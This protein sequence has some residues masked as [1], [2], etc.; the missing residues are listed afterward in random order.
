MAP[1]FCRNQISRDALA[2]G[3][4]ENSR[5]PRASARRLIGQLRGRWPGALRLIRISMNRNLTAAFAVAVLFVASHLQAQLPGTRLDSVFP[6]GAQAGQTVGVTISGI[7]L[8]DVDRL[9]FSHAGITAVRK[10]AEPGPFDNGPQPVENQFVVTVRGDVPP[11]QHEV[12]CQGKYGLSNP[13]TFVVDTLTQVVETEPNQDA[14]K[15]GEIT[16]PGVVTGQLNGGADVDLFRF[17]ANGGQ[18]LLIDGQ[19]RRIDSRSDVVLTVTAA[20]GRILAENRQGFAGDP[21]I[22]LTIPA[23]GEYYLQVRDSLYQGGADFV[24]RIVLSSRPHLDFVFPPAGAAGSNDEYTIYGRNLPGGQNSPLQIDGQTLQQLNVRI[25]IPGDIADKLTF[26]S[27]LDPHQAGLDGIEYRVNSPAGP[28][29]PILI[30]A[31]TAGAVREQPENNSPATAQKLTLPCEV[32]GQF[33]PQRDMDWYTFDAKANEVFFIEVYSH[34]LGLPTDPGLLVQRITKTDAGEEQV[35]QVVW[36]DDVTSN[37]R[38]KEFDHRTNDPWY[39]FTAPADGTYRVMVRDSYSAVKSDPRLVY[40]LAI[41]TEQPDFRLAAAPVDLQGSILL[42]KGAREAIRVTA[43]RR[44]GYEGEIRL[45]AEGLPNGVTSEEVVIGP[46]SDYSTLVLTAAENAPGGNGSV[47]IVGKGKVGNAEVTRVARVGRP[48]EPIQF[49]QPNS[50]VASISARL[51]DGIQLTVSDAEPALVSLTA[52][53]GKVIE[54]ARGGVLKIPYQVKRAE[55]AGGNITGFPIGLPPNVGV[56]QVGIGGNEKGD[57]ELRLQA[58]TPP[59]KYTFYLASMAQGV[60]YSRNPEAAE[61]AKKRQEEMAK[62]LMDAQQKFQ[63]SQQA[64]QQATNNLNQANNELNAANSAKTQADQAA[65]QAAAALKTATDQLNAAKQQL[66]TKPDDDGLKQA[67]ATAEANEK[68]AAEKSKAATEAATATAK[69]QEEAVAKQKAAQEAKTKADQEQQEA[70]QFQT[71]AQQEK[72]RADQK[73]QQT[74]QQANKRAFNFNTAS[75]PVTIQIAE[76][77]IT[78]TGPDAAT[79]K[80]GEAVD[81]PFKVTRLYEFNANVSVQPQL[82]GGVGGLSIP[83]INIDQNNTEGTVKITAA[84]NATPGEHAMTFR[85][86]M[87]FNGQNL[88]LDHPLKLTVVAVE[89]K[90]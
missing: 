84:A 44:D 18:R 57:F 47:R 5:E 87:N 49:Q 37:D 83:G 90:K 12:R 73:A 26:S 31:T 43:F 72:Q 52:G 59:G 4:P 78:R 45:S 8:D 34:R 54:T 42:R 40:R 86:Q 10:M 89:A 58:N 38:S 88:I 66:A 64:A 36:L 27:R 81:V 56:P 21:L 69:K 65:A 77:P 67:V 39:R 51:T 3:S 82:P 17:M 50:N 13:R 71:L 30:T 25:P 55:G 1:E 79:V 48:L 19:A 80:Q 15:A 63:A 29:N 11:G 22:D 14:E 76:F 16:V 23:N 53:E 32:L 61:A 62:A 46:G 9:T 60:Q 35:S 28:S 75:T 2:S 6:P 85:L 74:Q 20:D 24:Y 68:T 7:D 70:Q 33:F 41:R